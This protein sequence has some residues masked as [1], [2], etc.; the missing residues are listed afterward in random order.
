MNNPLRV[1]D[2]TVRLQHLGCE[3]ACRAGSWSA[4]ANA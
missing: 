3:I 4:E 1:I 2:I